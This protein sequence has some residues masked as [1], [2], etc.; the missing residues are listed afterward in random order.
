MHMNKFRLLSQIFYKYEVRS[1][2][3][4]NYL[5]PKTYWFVHPIPEPSLKLSF[6]GHTAPSMHV[7]LVWLCRTHELHFL[8]WGEKV[9]KHDRYI[10]ERSKSLG[11]I[12]VNQTR[13]TYAHDVHSYVLVMVWR[14]NVIATG[15]GCFQKKIELKV[16]FVC[17]L[18][19]VRTLYY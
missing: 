5:L 9:D 12:L 11:P 6:W 3:N 15:L 2:N 1:I 16:W 7:I 14:V 19:S 10:V 8:R 17:P 18:E 4:E 13:H